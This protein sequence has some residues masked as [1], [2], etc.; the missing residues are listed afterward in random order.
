M[1]H[2]LYKNPKLF[3]NKVSLNNIHK[4]WTASGSYVKKNLL[5]GNQPKG[6][7][8]KEHLHKPEWYIFCWKIQNC[9]YNLMSIKSHFTFHTIAHQ[10]KLHTVNSEICF[11]GRRT[12]FLFHLFYII[13]VINMILLFFILIFKFHFTRFRVGRRA[14]ALTWLHLW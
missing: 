6:K 10:N 11:H 13:C 4:L 12:R 9:F 7:R 14:L 5:E 2:V 8:G 1:I 3:S